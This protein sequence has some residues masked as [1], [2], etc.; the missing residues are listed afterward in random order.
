MQLQTLFIHLVKNYRENLFA[1]NGILF[2]H[3]FKKR[4]NFV[5][6]KIVEAAVKIRKQKILYL[7]FMRNAIGVML[8]NMSSLCGKY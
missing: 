5:T 3:E 7:K 6:R 8:K 4:T 1:C 2:N